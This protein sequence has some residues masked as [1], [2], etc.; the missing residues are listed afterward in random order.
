[1]GKSKYVNEMLVW[2]V[3][4]DERDNINSR[5]L[6]WD[7]DDFVLKYKREKNLEFVFP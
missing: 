4:K 6:N 5:R 7:I 2:Y 1:M 3:E